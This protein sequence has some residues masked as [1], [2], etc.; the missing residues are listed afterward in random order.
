MNRKSLCPFG[1]ERD[2]KEGYECPYCGN[3]VCE[4]CAK[5]WGGLCPNCYSALCR[6]S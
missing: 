6:I 3:H 1:G 2:F 4:S 5:S